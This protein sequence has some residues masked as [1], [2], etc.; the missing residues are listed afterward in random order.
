[1]GK[2]KT[3]FFGGAFDPVHLGH[4][5]GAEAV[6][7]QLGLDRVIFVPTAQSP[8][9]DEEPEAS[10]EDRRE[11]LRLALEENCRFRIDEMELARSGVSYTIGTVAAIR[12]KYHGKR[13]RWIIGADQV[14]KLPLWHRIDELVE[15]IEFVTLPRPGFTVTPPPI[16]G[17]RIHILQ[18]EA[19]AISSSEVRMRIKKQ[20]PVGLFLPKKVLEYIQDHDLYQR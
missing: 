18:C 16:R 7:E 4:V 12:E 11:M 20:L 5:R 13:L 14:E 10:K 6:C 3:A 19:M 1:M 9:K 15:I 2:Y 8:L 17:L